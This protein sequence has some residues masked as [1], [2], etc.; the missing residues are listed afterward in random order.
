MQ[1]I[2]LPHSSFT[3]DL[4]I[5]IKNRFTITKLKNR[6][7][8]FM[9]L[10]SFLPITTIGLISYNVSKTTIVN[11]HIISYTSN[12]QIFS[13]LLDIGLQE[14]QTASRQILA[15]SNIQGE[16]Y[17]RNGNRNSSSYF[18][19]YSTQ[20]FDQ[21]VKNIFLS[22]TYIDS[23][24][25]FD[26]YDRSYYYARGYSKG[27]IYNNVRLSDYSDK[28]WC[29]KAVEA[30][31][32]ETFFS[33]N[34]LNT[35]SDLNT[36]SCVKVIRSLDD[37]ENI[38]MLV[39]N[40]NKALIQRSFS[41]ST[42]NSSAG[43]YLVIDRSDKDNWRLVS[44]ENSSPYINYILSNM[45]SIFN[46]GIFENNYVLSSKLNNM[47]GWEIIHIIERSELVKDAKYIG[48]AT[49]LVSIFMTFVVVILFAIVSYMINKPLSQLEKVIADVAKGNRNIIEEFSNDEIGIIGNQFKAM[50]NNN[51]DLNERIMHAN[52]KQKEAELKALQAQINPHFLY[53]TLD[54][55]YWLAKFNKAEDIA[56]MTLSFSNIFK[57][58]L[59]KGEQFTSVKN[60]I[61]HIENYLTIQNIRYQ[62]KFISNIQVDEEIMDCKI[63]KLILQP[64]VENAIYHGLETKIGIG[65]IDILGIKQDNQIIFEIKDDGVGMNINA[66]IK[67]G[68]G[69]VN[70][71]ERIKLY[72]GDEYGANFE[73]VLDKGTKVTINL[74][75]K[76]L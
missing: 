29:K 69:I 26:N 8:F 33:Y 36:F 13:R 28:Y 2:K 39:I 3:Y 21:I 55:I 16:L 60:E 61:E 10:L 44:K 46:T 52:L 12:L 7:L 32:Y 67:T 27:I 70:V 50:V 31:G 49:L 65:H 30:N 37:F 18:K 15:D 54:S 51:L 66:E 76:N 14:I 74:P 59:N 25:I 56:V 72:Y 6:F 57:L 68:Y 4:L 64:F 42:Q 23:V 75:V 40:I 20:K 24:V 73:S 41:H 11:N 71:Q 45:G 19:V 1:L 48:T 34:V 35:D 22:N 9:V 38:G 5:R 43:A 63:V 62:N 53:N 47:T 58:S 17:S